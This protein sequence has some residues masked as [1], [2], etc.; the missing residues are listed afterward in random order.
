MQMEK[1]HNNSLFRGN[2]KVEKLVYRVCE[3]K[4]NGRRGLVMKG[5]RPP[6]V[7]GKMTAAALHLNVK[8]EAT[9]RLKWRFHV[10][11]YPLY[12]LFFAG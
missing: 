12:F 4:G 5:R 6:G 7:E 9:K 3:K 1:S 8:A 10:G 2:S 11:K